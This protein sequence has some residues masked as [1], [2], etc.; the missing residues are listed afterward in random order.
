MSQTWRSAVL[1]DVTVVL[2]IKR[3][4][5]WTETHEL[6][7]NGDYVVIPPEILNLSSDDVLGFDVDVP[8]PEGSDPAVAT[9]ATE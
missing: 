4:S 9:D 5:G 8:G 3:S 2:R 7:V 1:V 6:P